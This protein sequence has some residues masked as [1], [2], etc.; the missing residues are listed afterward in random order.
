MLRFL[1]E[2]LKALFTAA[3][4]PETERGGRGGLS[5]ELAYDGVCPVDLRYSCLYIAIRKIVEQYQSNEVHHR[6]T[7][8]IHVAEFH[9]VNSALVVVVECVKDKLEVSEPE[10]NPDLLQGHHEFLKL[11]LTSVV[12]INRTEGLSEVAILFFNALVNLAHNFFQAFIH[13]SRELYSWVGLSIV[14]NLHNS[15]KVP[16]VVQ[17]ILDLVRVKVV[18]PI[19]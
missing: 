14:C 12:L 15:V 19:V 18:T 4:L 16:L 5:P 8:S 6:I 3:C 9:K 11:K 17:V 2:L 7:V 13:K 10:F 1:V